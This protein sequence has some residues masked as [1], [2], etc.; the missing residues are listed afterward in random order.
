MPEVF[1]PGDTLYSL[2]PKATITLGGTFAPA[3]TVTIN[4][5]NRSFTTPV[6]SATLAT[7]VTNVVAAL[8]MSGISDAYRAEATSGTV[9]TLF[10]KG[11]IP[12]ITVSKTGDGT[13]AASTQFEAGPVLVGTIG[14]MNSEDSTI[15]LTG[16]AA[17]AV[18]AGGCI[19]TLFEEVYGIHLHSVDF[20]DRPS[21]DLNAVHGASRVYRQALP[22]VD[23]ALE[24]MFPKLIIN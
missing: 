16:D 15:V 18:S 6:G 19:G 2:E 9:L 7:V 13:I 24:A 14:S 5:G 12:N 11:D 3:D 21:V 4:L 20:T 1:L 8:N 23:K 22:Y 17:V 10:S